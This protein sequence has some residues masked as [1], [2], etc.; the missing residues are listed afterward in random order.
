MVKIYIDDDCITVRPEAISFS[1]IQN[2]VKNHIPFSNKYVTI[3]RGAE[4]EI[5][6]KVY[7]FSE[8]DKFK[9]NHY[10]R[11]IT[12]I[13]LNNITYFNAKYAGGLE[14]RRAAGKLYETEFDLILSPEE[15]SFTL[16]EK[17][18][19]LTLPNSGNY[20]AT[21]TFEIT[22]EATTDPITI[23]D[24]VRTLTCTKTLLITD[25]LKISDYQI[26][27]NDVDVSEYLSGD[28]PRIPEYQTTFT[29][30]ITGITASKVT[31]KYRETWR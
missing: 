20:Y 23:S 26:L 22:G 13:S 29:L 24:G 1:N 19:D 15:Y 12:K 6:L 8:A 4:K 30:T 25:V 17:T 28:Y 10:V 5:S 9:L 21:P 18:G 11:N 14:T 2:I 31:V 3:D 27:L 7:S 16:T